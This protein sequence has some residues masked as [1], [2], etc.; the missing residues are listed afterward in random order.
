VTGLA[1]VD[2]L[3]SWPRSLTLTGG[4]PFQQPDHE[5]EKF[6][7]NVLGTY[8]MDI[9]TN[10]TFP[11][12]DWAVGEATLILDWKLP[13]SGETLTQKQLDTREENAQKLSDPDCIKFTVKDVNDLDAARIVWGDLVDRVGS[14]ADFIVGGVWNKI[15]DRDIVNFILEHELPWK[16]N[17]QVHKYIWPEAERGV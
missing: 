17:V 16:L 9:F 3:S 1:L 6:A 15:S 7:E 12:P 14:Q 13:G 5:L 4:E 2:R 8:S 11:F 10:G